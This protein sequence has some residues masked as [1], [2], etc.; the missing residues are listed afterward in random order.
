VD[1]LRER[2]D[3][4]FDDIAFP[5]LPPFLGGAL[6]FID[7]EFRELAPE[8][9]V[10]VGFGPECGDLGVYF[11]RPVLWLLRVSQLNSDSLAPDGFGEVSVRDKILG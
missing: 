11:G 3:E 5:Q 4:H 8:A 10:K 1:T 7:E 6:S 2:V 9:N